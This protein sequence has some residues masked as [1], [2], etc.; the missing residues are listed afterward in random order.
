MWA[1]KW[2]IGNAISSENIIQDA[3]L[4]IGSRTSTIVDGEEITRVGTVVRLVQATFFKWPYLLMFLGVAIYLLVKYYKTFKINKI[5][6]TL[7][8]VSMVP[9][10]WFILTANHS[11]IHPRLV[12]RDWGIAI[13]S[14]LSIPIAGACK[15]ISGKTFEKS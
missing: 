7:A 6:I 11:Y 2:I 15:K 5:T 1:S 3:M 14:L 4:N 13:F 10:I 12:Y 9:I 8:L